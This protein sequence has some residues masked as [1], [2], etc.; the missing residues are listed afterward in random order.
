LVWPLIGGRGEQM[1]RARSRRY[2]ESVD[3]AALADRSADQLSYG[4]QKLL[5]LARA[6]NTSA[7]CLLL[8]EPTAGLSPRARGEIVTLIRSLAHE[9]LTV[10]AIEH[11]LAVVRELA[12]WVYVM[13]D[14]RVSGR[15]KPHEVD[16]RVMREATA[17]PDDFPVT[18]EPRNGR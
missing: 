4:Q 18:W 16:P 10:V 9:N 17:R 15:L 14:G 7:R 6:L 8:D 5:A 2:L 11:D 13:H 12:D 1:N 3:L